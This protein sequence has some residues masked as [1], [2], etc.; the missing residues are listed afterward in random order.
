MR[1]LPIYAVALMALLPAI[2]HAQTSASPLKTSDPRFEVTLD[3]AE[4][5]L[6]V[7]AVGQEAVDLLYPAAASELAERR[8]YNDRATALFEALAAGR[9]GAFEA[10][11]GRDRP[12]A[13]ADM[14][15]MLALHA[16]AYG[17]MTGFEV[18]GSVPRPEGGTYTYV[19]AAF[20]A[21]RVAFRLVWKDRRLMAL[22]PGTPAYMTSRIAPDPTLQTVSRQR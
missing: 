13:A 6:V 4:G 14:Q 15:R 7:R 12:R 1:K 11:V 17:A 5:G 20:G 9:S 3:A 16:D 8:R 19:V 21:E 10:A 18:L 2:A 22:Y